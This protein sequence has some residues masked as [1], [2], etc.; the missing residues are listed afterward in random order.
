MKNS[1]TWE[2][3]Q[4]LFLSAVAVAAKKC[5]ADVS[6]LG[7]GFVLLEQEWGQHYGIVFSG[8]TDDVLT[9]VCAYFQQWQA[10]NMG[11]LFSYDCQ[12]WPHQGEPT[13]VF[14]CKTEGLVVAQPWDKK[15]DLPEGVEI[16]DEYKKVDSRWCLSKPEEGNF[17]WYSVTISRTGLALSFCYYPCAE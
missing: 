8:C 5:G 1:V 12:R 3:W 15:E 7:I 17:K 11:H 2:N 9:R 6:G 13:R 4:S 14:D 16:G 10:K